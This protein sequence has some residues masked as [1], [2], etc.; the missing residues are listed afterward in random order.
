M[1]GFFSLLS[2]SV[3]TATHVY[4]TAALLLVVL[5]VMLIWTFGGIWVL[6]FLKF[7]LMFQ[8]ISQL[9]SAQKGIS[10]SKDKA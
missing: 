2:L 10:S 5:Y 7:T 8:E 3:A 1:F 6:H 9:S 4:F